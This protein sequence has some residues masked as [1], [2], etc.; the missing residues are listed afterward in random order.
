LRPLISSG[1]ANGFKEAN[2]ARFSRI[3]M[4]IPLMAITGA[5]A[6]AAESTI[7]TDSQRDAA[8]ARHAGSE[9]ANRAAIQKLL[10]RDD[11]RDMAAA[12]GLDV[13]RAEAAIATLDA[14]ELATLGAAAADAN[15]GL[16]GGDIERRHVVIGLAVIGAITVLAIL[17]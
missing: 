11:V 3:L 16:S 12:T 2:M 17:L 15:G 7:V 10:Q 8:I 4:L 1:A 13:V 6:E 14:D 5:F 9:D